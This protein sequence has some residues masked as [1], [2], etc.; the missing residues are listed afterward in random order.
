VTIEYRIN[1]SSYEPGWWRNSFNLPDCLY[2]P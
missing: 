2:R 1:L